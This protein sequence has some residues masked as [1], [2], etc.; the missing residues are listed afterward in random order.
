MSQTEPCNQCNSQNDAGNV[1]QRCDIFGIVETFPFDVSSLERKKKC[2][3][4]KY[5]FIAEQH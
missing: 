5:N 1:D 3:Q 4:L 2:T